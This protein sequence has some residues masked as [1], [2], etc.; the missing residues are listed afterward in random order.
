MRPTRHEEI[1]TI[2]FFFFGLV[3]M[4]ILIL[5]NW[6]IS[7]LGVYGR[8][9]HLIVFRIKIPVSKQCRIRLDTICGGS[10]PGLRLLH[11]SSTWVSYLE[12]VNS[13]RYYSK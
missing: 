5:L 9:F 4:S 1:K 2:N 3:E 10:E 13:F 11:M 12:R 7:S 8:C 6:S